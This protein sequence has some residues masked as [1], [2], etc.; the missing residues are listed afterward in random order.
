MGGS[1]L[2]GVRLLDLNPDLEK[3]RGRL[4]VLVELQRR[5]W[6]W[7]IA[8]WPVAETAQ[9]LGISLERTYASIKQ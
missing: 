5:W 1:T 7:A 4:G 9:V 8:A 3:A 6:I 2:R